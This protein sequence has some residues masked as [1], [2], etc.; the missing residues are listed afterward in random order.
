MI[1][2]ILDIWDDSANTPSHIWEVTNDRSLLYS[3]LTGVFTG[4][5]T[6]SICSS[7]VVYP[8][9]ADGTG[10]KAARFESFSLNP[11][12]KKNKSGDI[13]LEGNNL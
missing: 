10:E 11:V 12:P 9:D 1:L 8:E 3:V 7:D 5:F 2:P 13:I 6:N 4:E